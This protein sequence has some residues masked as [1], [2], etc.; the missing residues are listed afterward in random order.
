MQFQPESVKVM[1][2]L[3]Q[4]LK[5]GALFPPIE[6]VLS[7]LT[8]L[9]C[10]KQKAVPSFSVAV[11]GDTPGAGRVQQCKHIPKQGSQSRHSRR[12]LTESCSQECHISGSVLQN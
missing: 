8:F 9:S 2:S 12:E 6:P 10:F 3:G 4:R 5:T 11:C 1:K 7:K